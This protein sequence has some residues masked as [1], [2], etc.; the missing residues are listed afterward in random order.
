M[1]R[2]NPWNLILAL[3]LAVGLLHCAAGARAATPEQL[4]AG[5]IK[6]TQVS[7]GLIVHLG[8]GN[9]PLTSALGAKPG[10]LVQG[11]D[12]DP[13][14]VIQARRRIRA[15]GLYG[16]VTVDTLV[17]DRLPYMDNLVNLVLVE[18]PD[19]VATSEVIRVLRPGGIALVKQ[20]GG[21]QKTVKPW[22]GEIDEWTHFLHGPDNN[23][24]AHDRVVD[25]PRRLQWLGKPKFA[26]AHEQLA[27]MS[28]CVTTAGRLF[29]II[30]EAARADVRF[31][32]RWFLVARDAFNGVVLWKRPIAKWVDQLRSFRSGPAETAF[33]LAAQDDRLYVTLGI[34]AP[35]SIL[36]AVTGRTL[37]DC[38]GTEHARQVL[39]IDDK[40]V[41]L[42]DT[43]TAGHQGRG[44]ANPQRRGAGAGVPSHRGRRCRHRQDALAEGDRRLRASHALRTGRASLLPD[45]SER[46]LPEPGCRRADLE[47]RGPNAALGARTGLGV[48]HLG[49]R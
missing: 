3:P 35:V 21:W 49:D 25:I 32:S 9:T 39:R 47:S 41:A 7:G 38:E 1:N 16:Q 17:G 2:R 33:R 28:G 10:Y 27:S 48:A 6:D 4:A 45:Q 8:C 23:A 20:A 13:E 42:V 29:Y 12:R 26:R 18:D 24:V 40:L 46:P 15:L 43:T 19:D 30:D 36:D 11:L 5:I 31:P 37:A 44:R 22:P 34:D 14:V